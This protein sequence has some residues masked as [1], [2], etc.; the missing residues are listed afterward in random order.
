MYTT[1]HLGRLP[2]LCWKVGL[3]TFAYGAQI[4]GGEQHAQQPKQRTKAIP[5]N[6]K[7][8]IAVDLSDRL[9]ET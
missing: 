7:I 8:G 1:T 9:I 3:R 4:V 5:N 2:N 6:E